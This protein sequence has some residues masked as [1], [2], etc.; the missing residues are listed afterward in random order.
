[1]SRTYEVQ[2]YAQL[3]LAYK[4]PDEWFIADE[5]FI[6]Q[7]MP[8][9]KGKYRLDDLLSWFQLW[10]FHLGPDGY[11][12]AVDVGDSFIEWA[13][14][15]RGKHYPLPYDKLKDYASQGFSSSEQMKQVAWEYLIH[16]ALINKE[17]AMI[18]A[19]EDTTNNYDAANVHTQG[20]GDFAAA[21]ATTGRAGLAWSNP[22]STPLND[23]FF[24]KKE[25]K[26]AN[27]MVISWTTLSDLMLHPQILDHGGVAAPTRGEM[28]P[29]VSIPYLEAC[30]KLR[31]LVSKAEAVTAATADLPAASQSK[32]EMWG[33]YVWVGN[34]NKRS[35]G[36]RMA[37][38]TWGH[39]YIFAP[40]VDARGWIMKES[41]DDEKLITLVKLICGYYNQFK[42]WAKSYGQILQGIQ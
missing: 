3:A 16:A 39:Q 31:V 32:S 8:S 21:V 34:I 28:D 6:P 35:Q 37:Q 42:P 29:A 1:M 23:I 9:R 19:I 26:R 12:T 36:P 38:P 27:T 7:Y 4:D 40:L 17:A 10:D 20:S 2:E 33:D 18:T 14:D 24:L 25:N 11:T 15:P 41:I 13:T 22:N 5:I 30:F